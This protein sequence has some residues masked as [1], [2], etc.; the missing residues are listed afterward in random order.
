VP[1]APLSRVTWSNHLVPEATTVK[2]EMEHRARLGAPPD[3]RLRAAWRETYEDFVWSLINTPEFVW[4][5]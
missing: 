4:V 5:P 3:P 1:L 2:L